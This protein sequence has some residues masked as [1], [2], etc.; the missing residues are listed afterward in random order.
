MNKGTFTHGAPAG[1]ARSA[2]PPHAARRTGSW[3]RYRQTY[4]A[5]FRGLAAGR[6]RLALRGVPPLEAKAWIAASWD[7]SDEGKRARYYRL[8][9]LGDANN[10][11]ASTPSG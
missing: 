6:D 4:P 1:H 8:T 10:L 3:S 11:P 5:D 7:L 9:A 2:D